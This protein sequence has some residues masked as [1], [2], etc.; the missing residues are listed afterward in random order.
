MAPAIDVETEPETVVEPE[1]LVVAEPPAAIDDDDL[2]E[3]PDEPP[4]EHGAATPAPS[5]QAGSSQPLPERRVVVIDENAE[6]EA[7]SVSLP[8][9]S[10]I[11]QGP[12]S[13]PAVAE[14]GATLEEDDQPK[15]RW[16]LFR[17]G[18]E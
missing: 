18:G 16:R 3:D 5:A 7:S 4:P 12:A 14:I 11:A 8:A 13:A 6:L 9:R 10:R 15:R 2:W 17:K 1:P